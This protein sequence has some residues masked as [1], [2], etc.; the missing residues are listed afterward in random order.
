[1]QSQ[2]DV[3][4]HCEYLLLLVGDH[5]DAMLDAT[6]NQHSFRQTTKNSSSPRTVLIL[7]L[8]QWR[9]H[10][11]VTKTSSLTQELSTTL[12]G[13]IEPGAF[14]YLRCKYRHHRQP[15]PWFQLQHS[16]C[17]SSDELSKV[18]TMASISSSASSRPHCSMWRSSLVVARVVAYYYHYQPRS[19]TISD[20]SNFQQ[21]IIIY[22]IELKVSFVMPW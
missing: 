22:V 5:C 19:P 10:A 16:S 2:I 8:I 12:H 21:L 15:D 3:L 20:L 7:L 1:M 9:C 13:S 11:R 14:Q 4:R 17:C 6:N 18:S